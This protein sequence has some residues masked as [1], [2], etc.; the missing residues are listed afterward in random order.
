MSVVLRV[1]CLV[2]M[3]LVI[4]VGL[5]VSWWMLVG[6][7]DLVGLV[8]GCCVGVGLGLCLVMLCC[9]SY[10]YERCGCWFVLCM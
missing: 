3:C 6:F 10:L 1:G 8:V 2:L 7:I 9:F 4:E 5:F